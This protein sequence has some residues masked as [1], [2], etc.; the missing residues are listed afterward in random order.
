MRVITS[1]KTAM[2]VLALAAG[3][4][5]AADDR[6][7]PANQEIAIDGNRVS[8][9]DNPLVLPAPPV[10]DLATA[11]PWPNVPAEAIII[12]NDAFQKLP[13]KIKVFLYYHSCG[14]IISEGNED[15]ADEYA[16]R[17]GLGSGTLD[18]QTVAQICGT[19]LLKGWSH[20]P[21]NARCEK[22]LAAVRR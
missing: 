5:W 13:T 12:D 15:R 2:V 3:A 18:R 17:V 20:R 22:L 7:I 8:C 6:I 11:S 10:K 4:A 16:T 9:G 1:R 14:L 19:D 21:D